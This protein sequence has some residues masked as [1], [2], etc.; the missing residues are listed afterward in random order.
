MTTISEKQYISADR[1]EKD[2]WDFAKDLYGKGLD[3]DLIAGI[4]RGGAQISIYMQ[5]V[6]SL[7]SG[8]PKLF[9]A[10]HAQ[11]YTGIGM[12]GAVEVENIDSVLSRT[13]PGARVLVV[14]DIFD[15][16]RTFKAV[17]DCLR[18]SITHEDVSIELA[19]LYYKPENNEVDIVP[20][21]HHRI[22]KAED[23]IVLPHE[24]SELTED[25]LLS[26]GFS[27]P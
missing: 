25:E 27:M 10:I 17:Y 13:F 22:F 14:D 7:L 8:K 11:S 21:H 6:F 5:E 15:R 23:W 12:A 3:Y 18:K 16:G 26:K 4:T 2:C 19:A 1:L 24:L 9:A 20:D